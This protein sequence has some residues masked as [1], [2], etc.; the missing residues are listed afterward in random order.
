[1]KKNVLVIIG[2]IAGVLIIAGQILLSMW[3]AGPSLKECAHRLQPA[4]IEK[5]SVKAL[6]VEATGDPNATV[7]PA[8]ACS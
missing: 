1:M 4:I 2:C 6:V 5:P 7:G 3:N 8:S